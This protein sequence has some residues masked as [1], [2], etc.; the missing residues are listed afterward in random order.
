MISRWKTSLHNLA[1][2]IIAAFMAIRDPEV[3]ILAKGVS[4]LSVLYVI[5]PFD[6]IPDMIPVLG[7]LDDL[8]AVPLAAYLAGKLIP[9]DILS[10]LRARADVMVVRWGPRF[11]LLAV[12]FVLVWL[13]LAAI[14]GWLV[15]RSV[16]EPSRPGQYS[17]LPESPAPTVGNL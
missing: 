12:L 11:I 7:W 9:H 17:P 15:V 6:L 8:A 14:G 1:R 3:P 2:D 13:T 5:M 16:R 10:R 4:L